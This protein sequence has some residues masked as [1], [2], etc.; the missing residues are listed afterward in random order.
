MKTNKTML[1]VLTKKVSFVSQP[2]TSNSTLDE[3]EDLG[4]K[5]HSLDI[6]DVAYSS[7]YTRLASLAPAAAQA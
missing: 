2:Y 6:G 1:L 4:C 5:M 3:I 7:C